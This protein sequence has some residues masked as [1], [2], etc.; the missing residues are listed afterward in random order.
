MTLGTPTVHS[1]ALV[2]LAA[3]TIGGCV[4]PLEDGFETSLEEQG[5]CGDVVFYA[6]D[7]ADEVMLTL[8]VDDLLREAHLAGEEATTQ[9]D[10]PADEVTLIV[11]QGTKISDAT[12]DDVIENGGPTV[13]RAYTAVSGTV[14]ITARPGDENDYTSASGDMKLKD[15]VFESESGNKTIT[16]ETLSILNAEVGWFAG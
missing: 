2:F 6:V 13:E 4:A 11:E 10:L 12:C 14:E 5:G 15:V 3:A 8:V 16:L 9:F 1:I 7:S